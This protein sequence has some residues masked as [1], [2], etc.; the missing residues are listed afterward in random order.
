M[1]AV[2]VNL[3]D[4][5]GDVRIGQ[6]LRQRFRF[7][8][9]IGDLLQFRDGRFQDRRRGAEVIE[10]GSRQTRADAGHQMQ[11]DQIAFIVGK[12]HRRFH[13]RA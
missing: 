12:V 13:F 9:K 6:R 1:H 3:F 5:L 11:G 7:G 10:K 2:L 8:A 4:F